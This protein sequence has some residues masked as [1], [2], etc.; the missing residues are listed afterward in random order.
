VPTDLPELS[1]RKREAHTQTQTD[2]VT[3]VSVWVIIVL[4][5]LVLVLVQLLSDQSFSNP[6]TEWEYL[7]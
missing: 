1:A 2:I 5:T 6:T 3:M 7:F 4:G